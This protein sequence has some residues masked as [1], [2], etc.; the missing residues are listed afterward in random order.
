[1]TTYKFKRT[2][3]VT[4][5]MADEGEDFEGEPVRWPSLAFQKASA[6]EYRDSS[7]LD[8]DFSE[9]FIDV[10]TTPWEEVPC[11]KA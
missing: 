6:E 7:G 4:V 1:M 8:E 11:P 5:R 2:Q 9:D 10:D 3:T